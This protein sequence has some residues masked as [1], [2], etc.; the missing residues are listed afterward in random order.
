MRILHIRIENFGTISNLDLDCTQGLNIVLH[1]NGWGKS[2]LAAFI[3]T[4][5]YGLEGGR[6]RDFAVNDR[7][8]YQPWNKGFFGGEI[9]FEVNGKRYVLNRDFGTKD[10]DGKFA[11]FDAL[12]GLPSKDYTEN[13]GIELFGI[14]SES[15]KRTGF[16][17]HDMIKY[18][19]VNST[20]SSKV[21]TLSQTNDLNNFD[22]VDEDLKDYLNNHSPR[23]KN[24]SLYKLNE[25]IQVLNEE[26]KK[27]SAYKTQLLDLEEK[28]KVEQKEEAQLKE[29]RSAV[30]EQQRKL[31]EKKGKITALRTLHALHEETMARE[32]ST[33]ENLA[34]LGGILPSK[35]A[36]NTI[37]KLVNDARKRKSAL[38]QA[39]ESLDNTRYERLR[40]YFKEEPPTDEEV[41]K[42]LEQL[43][44]V[45]ELLK[46][47]EKR[48]RDIET[49]QKTVENLRGASL[50][51]GKE[52]EEKKKQRDEVLI[53][54]EK[55]KAQMKEAKERFENERKIYEEKVEQYHAKQKEYEEE[56]KKVE[57]L[58]AQLSAK[59]KA[60]GATLIP[61]IIAIIIGIAVA[62]VCFA[63]KITPVLYVVAVV[64]VLLGIIL[65]ILSFAGKKSNVAL[66]EFP[67]APSD[68]PLTPPVIPEILQFAPVLEV[69]ED[70]ARFDDEIRKNNE[71][72]TKC[73]KEIESLRGE[74]DSD[75]E[76]I[77]SLESELRTFLDRF[78]I[79]YSR[80]DAQDVLYEMK[81][82][83]GEFKEVTAAKEAQEED[84]A[85]Q[86]QELAALDVSLEEALHSLNKEFTD[87]ESA[88]KF[89]GDLSLQ[90]AAYD[91]AQSEYKQ[92][93]LKEDTYREE[94]G[95]VARLYDEKGVEEL[96]AEEDE[97]AL[98]ESLTT[99]LNEIN[100]GLDEKASHISSY[101]R[102][103]ETIYQELEQIEEK[104]E[105]KEAKKEVY[106]EGLAR[107][108]QVA[109]TRE[110][111][112]KSK[113]S[114]IARFMSPIK[115][116]F[117][118]YYGVMTTADGN[119][120]DFRVDAQMNFT[121]KEE[122]SYHDIQSQSEGY[123]DMIGTCIRFALLDVMYQNERPVVVMDDPFVNL[124]E[125]HLKSAKEFLKQVS[126]DYQIIYCTCHKD[127]A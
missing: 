64:L 60:S 15:Y 71:Q 92:A 8:R 95:E 116:S 55:Q 20:I 114:F 82:R 16:I 4:M 66:P 9:T 53:A 44:L 78:A 76:K 90:I 45:K 5:F 54:I 37:L 104:K 61:G 122:G 58:R 36:P 89:A 100:D 22:K 17:D 125:E 25:E 102:N 56:C 31:G 101:N 79:S 120:A 123:S 49:G 13:I 35:E 10:S 50:A 84:I 57:A 24:G 27:D 88:Q 72:E 126:A 127:R 28:K 1:P 3:R 7:M 80:Q 34:L 117:E 118:K 51:L 47:N 96:A 99:Q 23:K 32:E 112:Q 26:C 87:Y 107:Y 85:K 2:T 11:L 38:D 70:T 113:E 108:D 43:D 21:S 69:P 52:K 121:K 119:S 18:D 105:R 83:V 77:L 94:N 33:R 48:S 30:L 63:L 97:E 62:I 19:G 41:Q 91:S 124:D 59:K 110:Y 81:S 68:A 42:A 14:D 39:T 103:I 111:L 12:T 86:K 74:I 109:K 65:L 73:L 67:K 106:D 98:S 115:D 93:K 75:K 6:K 29:K 46:E 40:K